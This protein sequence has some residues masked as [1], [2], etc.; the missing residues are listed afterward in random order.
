[1]A[2]FREGNTRILVCTD[3]AGTLGINIP[4][5]DVVVQWKLPSTLSSFIQRAGVEPSA[6]KVDIV[7]TPEASTTKRRRRT[8]K[9]KPGG[10]INTSSTPVDSEGAGTVPTIGQRTRAQEAALKAYAI[11][12]GVARGSSKL[13]DAP[14]AGA[15]PQFSPDRDDEGLL[16]RKVWAEVFENDPNTLELC[17]SGIGC[18]DICVPTLFNRTRPG[19]YAAPKK[20][21]SLKKG[22]PDIA[23]VRKLM[24]WRTSIYKVHH[25][26]S[27]LCPLAISGDSLLLDLAS[28]GPV[29]A[30][31]IRQVLQPGGKFME[32]DYRYFS[33]V[34]RGCLRH[35]RRSQ[36]LRWQ[37]I[38]DH[39][40][41]RLVAWGKCM[42]GMS[43]FTSFI[44]MLC[45]LPELRRSIALSLR[46]KT[47]MRSRQTQSIRARVAQSARKLLCLSR[48][49]LE[50][51][52]AG[53]SIQGGMKILTR[54]RCLVEVDAR[55][56]SASGGVTALRSS[57]E[58]TN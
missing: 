27:L 54:D 29:G 7:T 30:D 17:T 57:N 52:L 26:Y 36:R 24:A 50:T 21:G 40:H 2:K 13:E 25:T 58:R 8:K 18:C 47:C 39:W 49:A 4:D 12:H 5:V 46:T 43:W 37:Q 22:L 9:V 33:K 45:I 42:I 28:C 20:T 32:G 23:T 1:M 34:Y 44:A 51:G 55:Q 15:Q 35:G 10:K 53:E 16:V 48:L 41:R 11:A 6:Y 56:V 31:K 19:K 3:A 38:Q 14:P